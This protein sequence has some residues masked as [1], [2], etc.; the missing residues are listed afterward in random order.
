MYYGGRDTTNE[1]PAHENVARKETP[2]EQRWF[3]FFNYLEIFS[4]EL[5]FSVSMASDLLLNLKPAK[6]KQNWDPYLP[7]RSDSDKLSILRFKLRALLF[8]KDE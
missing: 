2:L 6:S 4:S 1:K 7:R 3:F 5:L 8:L